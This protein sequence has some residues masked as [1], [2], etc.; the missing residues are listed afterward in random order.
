MRVLVTG[1]T[2]FVG[3]SVVQRLATEGHS[4]RLAVRHPKCD[5]PFECVHVPDIAGEVDWSVVLAGVD[6][7]IHLAARVHVMRKS[8]SD[9]VEF[10]R[11]NT[12]ATLRLARAAATA[13]ARRFVFLS[14][15]KVNGEVT[16]GQPF[17]SHDLPSPRDAYAVSKFQAELGLRDIEGLDVVILRPPLVY[18][19]G[20]KGNLARLCRFALLGIPV[21]FGAIGNRRDLVGVSN[22]ADLIARCVTHQA[23]VG[24]V[25]LAADGRALSTPEL[26]EMISTALGKTPRIFAAPVRTLEMFGRAIGRFD[27]VERLTQDLEVDISETCSV[28]GWQPPATIEQGVR[29][30]ANA[31]RSRAK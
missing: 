4:L 2:G 23:A 5:S 7:V 17:R 3:K 9:N 31:V 6:A 24:R 25:I 16:N 12:E 8:V 1:G 11:T 28:L 20:V 30:M 14:S 21:P 15:I 27:E 10:D 18:G 22:L 26:Y 29:E 19:P 13:G